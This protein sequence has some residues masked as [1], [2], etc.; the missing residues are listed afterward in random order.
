MALA[1]EDGVI[2]SQK[3]A[4]RFETFPVRMAFQAG[5]AQ[6]EPWTSG[7][8]FHCGIGYFHPFGQ[9]KYY[10]GDL[11]MAEV[12]QFPISDYFT[13]RFVE[14][15]CDMGFAIYRLPDG[16]IYCYDGIFGALIA[17]TEGVG[18]DVPSFRNDVL[19]NVVVGGTGRYAGARGMLMGTAEG[20]GDAKELKPGFFLP[21]GLL[22][23]LE[24]YLKIPV[25]E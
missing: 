10:M 17:G 6:Y 7:T 21:E 12:A 8:T 14:D 4:Q 25:Q 18:L 19:L 24:G 22:K 5:Y 20:S 16:D 15:F 9:C 2:A 1:Q 3:P 23:L 11:D 13:D